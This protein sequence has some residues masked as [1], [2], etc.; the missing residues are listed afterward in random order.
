M[1]S[2]FLDIFKQLWQI[3]V[4]DVCICVY[5]ILVLL[6][7]TVQYVGIGVKANG[8]PVHTRV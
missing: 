4:C 8:L 6:F 1:S 7:C 3:A 5:V 2:N